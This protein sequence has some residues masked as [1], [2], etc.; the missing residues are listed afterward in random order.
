MTT[1]ELLAATRV[2]V[3]DDE[4]TVLKFMRRMAHEVGVAE[5]YGVTSAEAALHWL[6]SHVGERTHDHAPLGDLLIISD[7]RLTGMNGCELGREVTRRW[8][9][10]RVLLVSGYLRQDLVE[11][12][13]CP[14][15]MPLLRKPFTPEEFADATIRTLQSPPWTPED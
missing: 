4:P 12:G 5:E 14:E 2:L 11:R 6:E 8:P 15:D 10:T 9:G 13:I 1:E 7:V 3:V